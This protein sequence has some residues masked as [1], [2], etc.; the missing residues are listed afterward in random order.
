MLVVNVHIGRTRED[1]FRTGRDPHDEFAR[2]LAPYGRFA[3]YLGKEYATALGYQPTLEESVEQRI[4]AIGS[5]DDVVDTLGM[6]RD[7]LGLEHLCCFFDMPGLTREQLDEQ[8][9]FLFAGEVAPAWGLAS[10]A[11]RL[12][13][14]HRRPAPR[15][16]PRR[17]PLRRPPPTP[18]RD[19]PDP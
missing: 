13:R 11:L 15:P 4:M 16:P 2:F 7:L 1:A 10:T 8:L 5:V 14:R 9:T 6:W 3:G 19:A 17:P 18:T 12:R